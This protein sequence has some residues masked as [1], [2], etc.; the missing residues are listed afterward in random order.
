MSGPNWRCIGPWPLCGHPRNTCT[1]SPAYQAA[2]KVKHASSMTTP[3]IAGLCKKLRE[4][5]EGVTPGTWYATDPDDNPSAIKADLGRCSVYVADAMRPSDQAFIAC[6]NPETLTVLLDT[7]ERQ[8]DE[9][10]RLRLA[11]VEAGMRIE[12]CPG[13][14]ESRVKLTVQKIRAALTGE[15]T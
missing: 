5:L 10:K 7:L 14:D 2:I 3:D 12:T 1:A 15:D 6:A 9:I 11:L 8:A 4:A 13:A